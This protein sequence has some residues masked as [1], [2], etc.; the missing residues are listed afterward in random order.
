MKAARKH[1]I[2]PIDMVVINLYR[3]EDTVAKPGCTLEEAIENIDIGGPTM[4]ARGSQK[5]LFRQHCHRTGGLRENPEGNGKD[6]GNDLG[7]DEFRA[8]CKGLPADGPIRRGHIKLPRPT[9][10]DGGKEGVPRYP[11][12]TVRQ[13]PRP[14]LRGKPHQKAA[15]YR[16]KDLAAAAISRA[17]QLQGKELSYN[18]IMDSDAAWLMVSDFKSRPPSS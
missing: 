12:G 9:E 10:Y 8:R 17:R 2:K 5:L 13:G 7:G 6:G 1:G 3:F 4:V 14:A 11:D 16:E 15:F 18:N